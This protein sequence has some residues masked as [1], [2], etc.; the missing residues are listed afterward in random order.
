MEGR[1]KKKTDGGDYDK[2]KSKRTPQLF[3]A[4]TNIHYKF[5]EEVLDPVH[6]HSSQSE[7]KA[8]DE[9]KREGQKSTTTRQKEK[10]KKEFMEEKMKRREVKNVSWL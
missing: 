8:D 2:L 9:E 5:I 1:R 6:Q 4:L 10:T 3:G 7:Q